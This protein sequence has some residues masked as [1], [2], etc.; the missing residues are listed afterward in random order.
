MLHVVWSGKWIHLFIFE[1]ELCGSGSHS[2]C[3]EIIDMLAVTRIVRERSRL[4][5][6]TRQLTSIADKLENT[7]PI[8]LLPTI[9]ID[10]R[11]PSSML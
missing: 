3:I 6:S 5:T 7:T 8:P 11:R 10:F 2:G 9:F 4:A 1:A